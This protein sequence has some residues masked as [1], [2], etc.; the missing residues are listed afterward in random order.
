MQT[1]VVDGLTKDYGHG[2]GIFDVTFDVERGDVLGFL[3]PNGAGKSTTMRH[4][5][6]FSKPQ[7]GH[8]SIAGL[9]C[10]REHSAVM[11]NV[12]YLPG[13]VA[14]PEGLD[15]RGFVRMMQGLRGMN[16]DG[17]A[18]QIAQRFQ[19]DAQGDI[20]KLSVGEKRKLAIVAAFMN[21][22]EVLLLDEPTSGLDPAMQEVFIEFMVEQKR[23][24]KT[25]LLSSHIFSEVEALC[26]RIAIIKEGRIIKVVNAQ[27][28][29]HFKRKSF[30]LSFTN[31]KA[32]STFKKAGF[33]VREEDTARLTLSVAVPDEQTNAF[34]RAAAAC[35]PATLVERQQTLEDYFMH[36]YKSDKTFGGVNRGKHHRGK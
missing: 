21:D 32:F 4:L 25:V 8:A 5:M 23:R 7:S 26:D 15:G 33:E 10:W 13:E 1:I 28:V 34:I 31:R 19:L 27:D 3:G 9:D 16:A 17:A 22:P 35:K 2:R 11:R 30:D 24:G 14:L 36:F 12:G 18:A 29:K 6:G 20:R